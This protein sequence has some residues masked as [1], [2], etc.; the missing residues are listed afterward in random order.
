MARFLSLALG[1]FCLSLSSSAAFAVS[2]AYSYIG[3]PLY[4]VEGPPDCS[5]TV[6][7]GLSGGFTTND[8]LR[9]EYTWRYESAGFGDT[10]VNTWPGN[11][12]EQVGATTFVDGITE[13][14]MT[15]DNAGMPTEWRYAYLGNG[16]EGSDGSEVYFSDFGQF[17]FDVLGFGES[18][19][20][21]RGPGEWTIS[22][23]PLPTS[24]SAIL[25]GVASIAFMR[26]FSRAS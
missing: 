12:P 24:L 10:L 1:V 6:F 2:L 23:I 3:Q 16:F 25:A 5:F 7:P 15:F 26:R 14:T 21:S 11:E 22:A 8:E 4:C 9:G 19:Y 18:I 20:A 13:F 17:G